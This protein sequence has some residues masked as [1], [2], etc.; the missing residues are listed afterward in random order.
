MLTD[1][2]NPDSFFQPYYRILPSDYNQH[3]HSSSTRKHA[4]RE[5]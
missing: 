1:M 5:K 3:A 2:E 4:T